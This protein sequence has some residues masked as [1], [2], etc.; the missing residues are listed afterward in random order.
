MLN[1]KK[2]I[3]YGSLMFVLMLYGVCNAGSRIS[4]FSH[5][6]VMAFQG[7]EGGT[8]GCLAGEW[9]L[10]VSESKIT[11]GTPKND[12]VLYEK[13][14]DNVKVTVDGFDD[15]GQRIH[16]EWAGKFDGKDYPVLG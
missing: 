12:T 8:P 6:W 5:P 15:H 11:P 14:N 16:N 13:A 4:A 7:C 10:N 1:I 9:E 2:V 3:P